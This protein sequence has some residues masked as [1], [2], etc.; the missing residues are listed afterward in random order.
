MMAA[1]SDVWQASTCS[2]VAR[3]L[4]GATSTL[5]TAPFGIPAIS[6]MGVGKGAAPGF[7]FPIM[8]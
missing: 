2:V 3:S 5:S 7:Q 4:N 1:I 6:A 8:A